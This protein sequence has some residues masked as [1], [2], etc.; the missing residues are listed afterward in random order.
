MDI[1][2]F[3]AELHSEG[4]AYSS[5]NSYRSAISSVH[6]HVDGHPIGQHPQI[7]RVLKGVYNLCPPKPRYSG[8]WKVHTVTT[9]LDTISSSDKKVSMIDLSVKTALLLALTRPLRSS[10]LAG[11]SLAS[12]RYIPEGAVFSADKLAKQSFAGRPIKDFF[13]PSFPDNPNLCPVNTLKVYIERTKVKRGSEKN[14]FITAVGKHHS[15]TS[16][17]IARWIKTGLSKAGVNTSIFKAHSVRSAA[18]SAAADAGVSVTEIM[19]AADWTSA[20]VFEKFYYR[21]SRSSTF[22]HTV[23]SSA[24]NLQS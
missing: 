16:A 1:S 5:L 14:L 24:S 12:L 13:F 8:T 10:D 17:T 6:E 15:A 21:P 22:G 9:W 19:E 23:I 4:Y 11:L 7:S 3:L 2:N 18:S 20:S